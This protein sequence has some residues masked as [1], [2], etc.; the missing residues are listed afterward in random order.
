MFFSQINIKTNSLH[1]NNTL[2]HPLAA[3]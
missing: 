2:L 1:T 3:H